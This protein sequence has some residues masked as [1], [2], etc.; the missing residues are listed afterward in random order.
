MRGASAIAVTLFH[1]NEPY[2]ALPDVYHRAL[3][4][5]WLGVPVFFVISGFCIAAAR[6]KDRLLSFWFRRLARIF[7]P[8]WA[9]LM[10]VLAIVGLRIATAGTNDITALPKGADGWFYTFIALTSPASHVTG[11][12]WVY[13]SLSYELVFYISLGLLTMRYS[14]FALSAF[15]IIAFFCH[16]FPFDLWG[17]F[18]LGAACHHCTRRDY[19]AALMI[20][21]ICLASI[22]VKLSLP[23]LL[24]GSLTALLIILPPAFILSPLFRPLSSVGVFS[25]SLYTAQHEAQLERDVEIDGANCH[26]SP[27]G[28]AH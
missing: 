3:K 16:G 27:L 12:N 9:S 10:L 8:Y 13:W 21:L 17:L 20:G 1:F 25:Y 24:A 15:S 5:G 11:L 4:W 22:C 28:P 19:K 18:G 7:P 23:Y 2:P 26:D 6:E 14:A